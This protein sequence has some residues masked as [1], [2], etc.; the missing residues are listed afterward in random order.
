MKQPDTHHRRS[1]RLKEYDY[2]RAGAYFITICTY[3]REFLF[4]EISDAAMVLNE[5]GR[6]VERCWFDLPNH[7]DN[8]E[9]HEYVIMPNHFYGKI[10]VRATM[11]TRRVPTIEQFGKPT[12]N[13]IPA[14][15]RG[16]KSTVT[17]QINILRQT[18]GVPVWQRN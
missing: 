7:Y 9:L 2:S 6:I 8:V 17:K 1:I 18:P 11:E 4:G 12:S 3:N 13:T 16:F 10:S 14:I 5:Y 15:I